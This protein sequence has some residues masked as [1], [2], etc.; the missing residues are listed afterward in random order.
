MASEDLFRFQQYEDPLAQEKGAE[1][2]LGLVEQGELA[3]DA[4]KIALLKGPEEG[5]IEERARKDRS[6]FQE[7]DIV[8]EEQAEEVLKKGGK[9]REESSPG[10]LQCM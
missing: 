2:R 7:D 9:M 5:A 4:V 8:L 6:F 3:E 10:F 1:S